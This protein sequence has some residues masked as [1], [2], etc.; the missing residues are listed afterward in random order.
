[1]RISTIITL[2]AKNIEIKFA[3]FIPKKKIPLPYKL[4]IQITNDCNSKCSNCQIWKIN[5]SDPSL[6]ELE[7]K[8]DD[9]EKIFQQYNKD[10][11]WLALSGGE[12]TLGHQTKTIIESAIKHCPSLRIITFTTNGLLPDKVVELASFIKKQNVDMFVTIS[13]DGTEATHNKLRGVQN[14]FQLAQI[15]HKQLKE[16]KIP[17][18]FGLT[19]HEE[20]AEDIVSNFKLLSSKIRAI[21]LSHT[22]GIFR[23]DKNINDQILQPALKAVVKNYKPRN[24]G[25]I[26]E[27]VYLKLGV[28]F[29]KNGRK[30]SPVPCEVLTTSAHITPHGEFLSSC[31]QSSTTALTPSTTECFFLYF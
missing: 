28:V 3:K 24:L 14:N 6:K 11:L 23:I 9:Y 10:L 29:L 16:L 21:S 26:V 30:K 2:I 7:L 5:K 8:V 22:K 31:Y 18:H 25:E 19:I 1:M 13:L 15:C 4:L 20:N 27:F 17:V 12:V